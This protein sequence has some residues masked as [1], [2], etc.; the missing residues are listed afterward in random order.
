[1]ERLTP[2]QVEL[3]VAHTTVYTCDGWCVF[4]CWDV[5]VVQMAEVVQFMLVKDQK[6]IPIR[7]AGRAMLESCVCAGELW[8]FSLTLPVRQGGVCGDMRNHENVS[9]MFHKPLTLFGFQT[10]SDTC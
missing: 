1:M 10:S 4:S 9:Q 2:A 6:K 7:R 3:K 8:K 5:C